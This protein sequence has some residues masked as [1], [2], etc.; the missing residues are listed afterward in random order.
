MNGRRR[1][2]TLEEVQQRAFKMLFVH[3]STTYEEKLQELLLDTLEER[4]H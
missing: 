1:K 2:K 3:S 4:R